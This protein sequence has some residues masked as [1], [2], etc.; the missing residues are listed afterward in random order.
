MTST[1]KH[2]VLGYAIDD[3][4]HSHIDFK[5]NFILDEL[6][7]TGAQGSI[8][9]TFPASKKRKTVCMITKSLSLGAEYRDETIT[10]SVQEYILMRKLNMFHY[11]GISWGENKE[12]ILL[13]MEMLQYSLSDAVD[14]ALDDPIHDFN[15]IRS[16]IGL[17]YLIL[18]VTSFLHRLHDR[19]Y[20]HLD[21]KPDNIMF[22]NHKN[23]HTLFYGNGFKV[24]DLGL[25]EYVGR[26]TAIA[27]DC[28]VGTKGYAA[29]EMYDMHPG[30]TADI[31]SLGAVVLY[32][33]NGHNVFENKDPKHVDINTHLIDLYLSNTINF[34]LYDLLSQM[35]EYEPDKRPSARDIL[36]HSY[37]EGLVFE[38]K[39]GELYC[40]RNPSR[41][42]SK[43]KQQT[44][45]PFAPLTARLVH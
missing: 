27:L 38:G 20:V 3:I 2:M 41:Y 18:E 23:E 1:S 15:C 30:Y 42:V 44:M 8:Y 4:I 13:T 6:L 14:F 25:A 45:T 39:N 36:K 16:D 5:S 37:F 26:N 21:V 31:W 32:A 9:S 22:R 29:P 11:N 34:K 43:S 10:H 12:S 40:Y 24:I 7:L 33:L 35:L 19:G 17:Q 28:F